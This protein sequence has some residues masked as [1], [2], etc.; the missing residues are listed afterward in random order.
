M[1]ATIEIPEKEVE[2]IVTFLNTLLADEYALYTKT[3]NAH[4][5]V[6]GPEL[7]KF[8]ET[9]YKAIDIIIS[10]I[11]ER[12][13]ALGHYAM[14]SLKDFLHVTHL[15][16]EIHDFSNPHQIIQTLANDHETIMRIIKNEI[17]P[18]SEKLKELGTADF[19]TALLR[20]HEK[21]AGTLRS[22]A[23]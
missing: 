12:V 19:V 15:D 11:A 16:Q 7:R 21:M 20:Q 23:P 3:R 6:K 18:I 10:D 13:R 14:G 5:N 2:G 4:W 1:Q 17:T 9:Q 22:F 8:F